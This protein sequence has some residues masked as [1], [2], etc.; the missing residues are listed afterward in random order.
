LAPTVASD[1][2]LEKALHH[3]ESAGVIVFP[4]DTLWGMG[5]DTFSIPALT[6]VFSI[7]GRPVNAPLPVLVSGWEQVDQVAKDVPDIGH[8]LASRFWPGA[9]TL[10]FRRT[11]AVPDLVTAGK[12]TV[13][14]RMPDHRIPLALAEGL[15]RPIIGTSANRSGDP[16][17]GAIDEVE[18]VLGRDVDYIIRHGPSPQ[19][20]AST[21]VDVSEGAPIL[22]RQGAVPFGEVL[23]CAGG[24]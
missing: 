7:K 20:L 9:L 16:D 13:A 18:E 21:V 5:C 10:V 17:L 23:R 19:G 4:T 14:V 8:R 11:V 15:G 1:P 6:R 3:L 22:L 12:D 24:R 2:E